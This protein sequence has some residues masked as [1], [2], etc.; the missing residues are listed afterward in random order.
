[1][2][3]DSARDGTG[4]VG[5]TMNRSCCSA[6]TPREAGERGIVAVLTAIL[7][8]ILFGVLA[9][10]INHGYASLIQREVRAAAD[11]AAHAATVSLCGTTA[12]WEDA[13]AAAL[14][15]LRRYAVHGRLGDAA[16]IDLDPDGG[17]V[18]EDRTSNWR[19]AIERGRWLPGG[20]FVSLEA[21]PSHSG[22]AEPLRMAANAVRVSVKRPKVPYLAV[23]AWLAGESYSVESRA[24]AV[25]GSP[26]AACVAPFA[27][28]VC[29]LVHNGEFSQNGQTVADRFF[30]RANRYCDGEDAETAGCRAIVPESFYTPTGD[31]ED[32]VTVAPPAC[33]WNN[34]RFEEPSDHFGVVGLP[35]S[36]GSVTE[37]RVREVI[38]NATRP[39][40]PARL[41]EVFRVLR[42]GLT[43]PETDDALWRQIS[44]SYDGRDPTHP[45]YASVY[46]MSAGTKHHDEGACSGVPAAGLGW[47]ACNS[48]RYV[49]NGVHA[50]TYFPEERF[51][52]GFRP[53]AIESSVT[54]PAVSPAT[55]L[56]RVQIPVIAPRGESTLECPGAAATGAD[57]PW[58][59]SHREYEIIGFVPMN[60]F[61]TD[62]GA[63]PP[64]NPS[65][66]T[67]DSWDENGSD[68][69]W[70]F[71]RARDAAP[72]EPTGA[73]STGPGRV[74]RDGGCNAVRGRVAKETDYLAM[75]QTG[76]SA[77][78]LV[79]ERPVTATCTYDGIHRVWWLRCNEFLG[80]F[81]TE[82]GCH[83]LKAELEA[84]NCS[85]RVGGSE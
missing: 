2:R 35:E 16:G 66:I 62:V 31:F 40:V 60:L 38:E 58:V 25:K 22:S 9:L 17:P 82:A 53:G 51:G 54:W 50:R 76:T 77:V 61:D 6:T 20:R 56:W 84:N 43:E 11:A 29:A 69:V 19:I 27:L 37:S 79:Y 23:P 15:T 34:T 8:A 73:V 48:R 41:G 45:Q 18:W 85:S 65:L 10:A 67:H 75:D 44:V 14:N 24:T 78:S 64:L 57:D 1:M 52:H 80:A 46:G 70:G 59:S 26:E 63:P 71:N 3:P 30:T 68:T 39:C 28:P 13:K 7:S 5:V 21:E 83:Q 32:G 74:S 36:S 33:S 12:C 49:Y 4:N 42:D 72:E 81:W 47:G 55:P